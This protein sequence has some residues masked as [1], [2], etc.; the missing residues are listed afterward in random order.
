MPREGPGN[1]RV[2]GAAAAAAVAVP[3][4]AD[5]PRG[6]TGARRQPAPES[7]GRCW[8]DFQH[9]V[10]ARDLEIAVRENYVSVEHL[11]RYTTIGMS[12]DQGKTSN[13]NALAILARL[14]DRS[15]AQT[16]TTT[17]RPPF[18]PVTL[19]TIAA[20]RT[21]RFYRPTRELPTHELQ[22]QLGGVFEEFGGWQ[23]PVAYP[24]AGEDLEAGDRA[25]GAHSALDRRHLR[26]LAARQDPRSRP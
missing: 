21:G 4:F 22:Q 13:L 3:A 6:R 19:G 17:F 24:C 2:V 5:V 18:T 7:A 20:G 15:I 23:R 14:T 9:D 16:G 11:K 1:L 12:V 25:G 8:I 26:G 10:T